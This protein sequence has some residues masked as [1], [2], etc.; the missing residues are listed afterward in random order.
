MCGQAGAFSTSALSQFELDRVNK[1][2]ILNSFRGIDSTGAMWYHANRSEKNK[3]G[4]LKRDEHPFYF[5]QVTQPIDI[6]KDTWGK[7][8][9]P[10]LYAVHCRAATIGNIKKENAHPFHVDHIIGMHN[11][12]IHSDFANKKQFET[13]SE[14]LYHNIATMGVEEAIKDLPTSAAYALVW[15]NTKE[16]TLN[17]LRNSQRPLHVYHSG[18]TIYWSSDAKDLRYTFYDVH[19]SES[20]TS[21]GLDKHKTCYFDTNF[22]YKVS[23]SQTARDITW[24]RTEVKPKPVYAYSSGGSWNQGAFF[25]QMG[26]ESGASSSTAGSPSTKPLATTSKTQTGAS[27]AGITR[28]TRHGGAGRDTGDVFPAWALEAVQYHLVKEPLETFKPLGVYVRTGYHGQLYYA[29]ELDMYFTPPAYAS[30]CLWRMVNRQA[31]LNAVLAEWQKRSK[32]QQKACLKEIGISRQEM[33]TLLKGFA[34]NAYIDKPFAVNQEGERIYLHFLPGEILRAQ[35][36]KRKANLTL[37]HT[38]KQAA[39]D[40]IDGV[41]VDFN[42]DIPFDVDEPQ[43]DPTTPFQF[44]AISE[45]DPSINQFIYDYGV[46]TVGTRREIEEILKVGCYWCSDAESFHNLTDLFWVSNEQFLCTG[47]QDKVL[48]GEIIIDLIPRHYDIPSFVEA[49]RKRDAELDAELNINLP[50]IVH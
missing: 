30:L 50:A 44:Q 26:S 19:A 43:P 3:F 49:R 24:E 27:T 36:T 8:G 28:T 48:D 38:A 13:D 16:K 42:D 46:N 14:A 20:K 4:F 39:E 12:S 11:G 37:I 25:P 2:L 31:F 6:S 23:L 32:N 15:L 47:C 41:D 1:L 21:D 22:H 40:A 17:F 45:W 35:D 5:E 29:L 33:K 34:S 10:H 9:L 18:N 7:A